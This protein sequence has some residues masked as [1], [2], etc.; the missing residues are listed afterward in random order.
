MEHD[1]D[2][3]SLEKGYV[4]DSIIKTPIS[5]LKTI[6]EDMLKIIECVGE[7]NKRKIL[8]QLSFATS[9]WSVKDGELISSK[10]IDN[11]V[12]PSNPSYAMIYD[13]VTEELRAGRD[14]GDIISLD[15]ESMSP[16]IRYRDT[17]TNTNLIIWYEDTRSTL[18][19]I[20]LAKR[21]D[22]GG[23]SIWRIGIIPNYYGEIRD[24]IKLDIWELINQLN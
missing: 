19:K 3:K 20:N 6:E 8:M 22:L 17:E 14:I 11:R 4:G 16:Y 10:I 9:Q 13:R 5:P 18:A 1:Y 23:I 12:Y 2:D 24:E 21:L 7:E 15:T